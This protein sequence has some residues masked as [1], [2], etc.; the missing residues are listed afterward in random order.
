L[1]I[2]YDEVSVERTVFRDG[3]NEYVI[4]G[5]KVRAK[6]VVELLTSA[7][8]GSSGHHIISQGEA[9]KILSISP[10]DRKSV[11]E[12]ALGLK[13]F[14]I[15]KQESERKLDKTEENLKEVKVRERVN[16]P[17]IRFLEKEVEKIQKSKDLKEELIRLYQN[18]FPHKNDVKKSISEI[19]EKISLVEKERD[20][21]KEKISQKN[22]ELEK[23]KNEVVDKN[24]DGKEKQIL[25]LE[26]EKENFVL[27]RKELEKEKARLDYEIERM[28]KE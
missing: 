22:D 4:N 17:R 24:N 20:S 9:D 27:E 10:K 5:S 19:N 6:D 26:K 21:L 3:A 2:D 11:L 15:K 18:F 23:S 25:D 13:S 14:V 7:N 8:I 12:E 1:N 16:A 28:E